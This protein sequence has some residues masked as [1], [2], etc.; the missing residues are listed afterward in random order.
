M[1]LG[2]GAMRR[3][4]KLVFVGCVL[5]H[6]LVDSKECLM[7]VDCERTRKHSAAMKIRPWSKQDTGSWVCL[8]T[9]SGKNSFNL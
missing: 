4:G 9:L 3:T 2:Y 1:G 6:A 7:G 8:G 5:Y